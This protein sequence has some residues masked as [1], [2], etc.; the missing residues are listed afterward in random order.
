MCLCA[1]VFCMRKNRSEVVGRDF[2]K[3]EEERKRLG[4]RNAGV[5]KEFGR[6]LGT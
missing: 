3:V 1:C 4:K 5:K 2:D 6:S